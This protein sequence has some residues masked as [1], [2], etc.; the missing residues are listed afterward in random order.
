MVSCTFAQQV[1]MNLVLV[2]WMPARVPR[3]SPSLYLCSGRSLMNGVLRLTHRV[4]DARLQEN[5]YEY[6][7]RRRSEADAMIRTKC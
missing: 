7:R 4:N 6:A 5:Q 1:P 3:D 2:R